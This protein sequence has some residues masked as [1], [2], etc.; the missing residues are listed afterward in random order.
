MG[1]SAVGTKSAACAVVPKR[2][3]APK[4]A[5]VYDGIPKH[6]HEVRIT[7]PR[8]RHETVSAS[9]WRG[10]DLA[11]PGG[12]RTVPKPVCSFSDAGVSSGTH[13]FFTSVLD[14]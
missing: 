14:L 7:S 9:D 13:G 12:E 5:S 8:T 4:A 1:G 11:R 10:K 3:T 6:G 2:A